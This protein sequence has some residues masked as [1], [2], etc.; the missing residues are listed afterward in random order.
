M[1]NGHG[2]ARPGAGRKPKAEKYESQIEAANQQ[3]A[4]HLPMIVGNLLKLAGGGFEMVENKYQPDWYVLATINKSQSRKK[5]KAE[6]IQEGGEGGL[7][8]NE[9]TLTVHRGLSLIEQKVTYAQPNLQALIYLTN[10]I[11]GTPV[12][13][14]A[15]TDT[16]GQDIKPE[17]GQSALDKITSAIARFAPGGAATGNTVKPQ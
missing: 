11:M 14:V 13:M 17:D 2:G 9:E 12:Q 3:I 7:E 10:R 16:D 1:A 5:S 4:D 6:P 15:Q 8:L